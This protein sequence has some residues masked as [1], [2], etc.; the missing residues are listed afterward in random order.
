MSDYTKTTDF[1]AKDALSTGDPNKKTKGTEVDTEF[2]NIATAVATK[3]DSA[4]LGVVVQ[5]YDAELAA[6]AG[7]TSAADKVPYFTGSGTASV[8]TLT[9]AARTLIAAVDAAA[10]RTA[11]G[12][13]ASGA[14][15]DITSLAAPAL[16]AATATTQS[17]GDNTTKVATTA[18]VTA[19]IPAA[20]TTVRGIVELA[21]SA[22]A[23]AGSDAVRAITPAT[24]FGGLNAS[25]S[26]PIYACR[27]WVNFNGQGTVA[28]RASGNVSSITDN[29]VGNYTVNF[30]TAMPDANYA[31]MG[32]GSFVQAERCG[33]DGTSIFTTS[34]T[35]RT[36]DSSAVADPPMVFC[37]VFK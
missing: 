4:D 20:S 37:A 35:I 19:A 13:A 10:Q 16:G 26:A 24:L 14:N 18:F 30:T 33:L 31:V 22:E 6:L 29:S 12:A 25:G 2:N 34:F 3:Y 7:L 36:A 28:I 8:A 5:A 11:L 21:T 27:A 9:A 15:A 17:P 23:I 32:W 1:A